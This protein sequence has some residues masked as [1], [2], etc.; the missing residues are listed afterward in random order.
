MCELLEDSANDRSFDLIDAAFTMDG[1][2]GRIDLANNIIT[3]AQTASRLALTNSAFQPAPRFLSEILEE[4]SI[5][6]ALET[7][8]QFTNVTLGQGH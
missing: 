8:M 5:H 1:F 7:D 4:Q 3:E 6:G 2:T